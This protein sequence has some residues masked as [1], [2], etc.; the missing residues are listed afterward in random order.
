MHILPTEPCTLLLVTP[1]VALRAQARLHHRLCSHPGAPSLQRL[2]S[3][4]LRA[5]LLAFR[6]QQAY[7]DTTSSLTSSSQASYPSDQVTPAQ[8]S[9]DPQAASCQVT[10]TKNSDAPNRQEASV[11]RLL[12]KGRRLFAIPYM[13][14]WIEQ[15]S[16]LQPIIQAGRCQVLTGERGWGWPTEGYM[17][18]VQHTNGVDER[19][20]EDPCTM[21]HTERV[22]VVQFS[23]NCPHL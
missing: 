16:P 10:T 17:G 11:R 4:G 3:T 8:R 18:L 14:G 15:C 7:H 2:Y 19:L 22:F 9:S 21:T 13:T 5:L 6:T 23:D 12:T 1:T 20:K